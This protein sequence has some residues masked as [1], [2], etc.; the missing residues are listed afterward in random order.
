LKKQ[1]A[2]LVVYHPKTG[3][4][5]TLK[6]RLSKSTFEKFLR[7]NLNDNKK[8]PFHNFTNDKIEV[9]KCESTVGE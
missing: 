5:V 8:L 2:G 9:H 1:S 3:S 7:A 4:Y 6:A